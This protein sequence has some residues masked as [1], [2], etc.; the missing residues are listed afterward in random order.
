MSQ[1]VPHLQEVR[2]TT[3]RPYRHVS[4]QHMYCTTASFEIET[5]KILF[6]PLLQEFYFSVYHTIH[7][8]VL[9]YYTKN[10]IP[11]VYVHFS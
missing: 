5:T 10:N 2:N 8:L 6:F 9:F 11:N 3:S 7:F 1:V 4:M